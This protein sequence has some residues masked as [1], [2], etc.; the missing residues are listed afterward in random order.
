MLCLLTITTIGQARLKL[1]ASG[2]L[3]IGAL[4]NSIE[5]NGEEQWRTSIA[6]VITLEPSIKLRWE[7][8]FALSFGGGI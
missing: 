5:N 1:A 8:S 4:Y 7:N 6:P 2:R 3:T